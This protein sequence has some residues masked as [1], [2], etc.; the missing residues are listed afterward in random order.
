MYCPLND[1]HIVDSVQTFAFETF[2]EIFKARGK[3]FNKDRPIKLRGGNNFHRLICDL[4]VIQIQDNDFFF[5]DK[6][7]ADESR[8]NLLN[9]FWIRN[10]MQIEKPFIPPSTLREIPFVAAAVMNLKTKWPEKH[11]AGKWEYEIKPEDS[12]SQ[13]PLNIKGYWLSKVPIA[14]EEDKEV[15]A[16]IDLGEDFSIRLSDINA[17]GKECE[18]ENELSLYSKVVN[19]R[20]S[21]FEKGPLIAPCIEEEKIVKNH[22]AGLY[23]SCDEGIYHVRINSSEALTKLKLNEKGVEA[24]AETKADCDILITSCVSHERSYSLK[25][26]NGLVI[27]IRY[28]NQTIFVAYIPQEYFQRK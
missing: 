12:H 6:I 8:K 22:L 1:G 26:I 10:K 18:F 20:F 19:K 25:I 17:F 3:I 16:C 24:R 11:G 14:L 4:P 15:S 7:V 5:F 23:W 2:K 9:D 13:T 28:K 27:D 21:Y